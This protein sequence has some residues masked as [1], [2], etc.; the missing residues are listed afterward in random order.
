MNSLQKALVSFGLILVFAALI[1]G[2]V[3]YYLKVT[4]KM[5]ENKMITLDMR[6]KQKIFDEYLMYQISKKEMFYLFLLS[7]QN[8]ELFNKKYGPRL[9]EYYINKVLKEISIYLPY[10]GKISLK[11][12]KT[13]IVYYPD[14]SKNIDDVAYMLKQAAMKVFTYQ[15]ISLSKIVNIS[16][17]DYETYLEEQLNLK[18]ETGLALSTKELGQIYYATNENIKEIDDYKDTL[19]KLQETPIKLLLYKVE[20]IIRKEYKEI[21][22]KPLFNDLIFN[23]FLNSIL[24]KEKAWVNIYLLELYLMY[25][26]KEEIK[27]II[28]IPISINTLEKEEFINVFENLLIN[29]QYVFEQTVLTLILNDA[30]DEQNVMK[31]ILNLIN[32]GVKISLQI[33]DV[34]A[35]LFQI[36]Q[37]LNIKRIVI[38][39]N[40]IDDEK[41]AELLYF[42]N[43][44]G[45]EVVYLTNNEKVDISKHKVTHLA[46]INKY[47]EITDNKK[48]RGKK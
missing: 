25:L 17:I 39:D 5:K 23:N 7:I 31:N 24:E 9:Q 27:S 10:G 37:K 42:C 30:K 44:N 15:N 32:L 35:E 28:N 41:T 1:F 6:I 33:D 12:D 18:L 11:D 36:I 21:Y 29:N 45:I 14:V 13:I 43:V 8:L 2:L 38:D 4:K 40:L 3:Y 22:L 47:L 16:Y 48:K 20:N 46:T 34:T 26:Y 19:K